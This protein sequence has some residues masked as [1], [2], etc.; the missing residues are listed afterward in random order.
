VFDEIRN[1]FAMLPESRARGYTQGRF[2]YNVRGGRCEACEGNGDQR[3]E[4]HFLPDVSVTCHVCDGKRYNRET[5]EVTYKGKNI[6]DV[7]DMDA[8][9]AL[10]FFSGIPKIRKMLQIIN[11]IGLGYLRLGQ[12]GPSLSAGEAQR[13]KLS[14]ELKTSLKNKTLYL[15]D[16]P[17]VGLHFY[18]I[19][20]LL[21]IINRLV[22]RGN[23]V[24]IIEHNLEVVAAADWIIDLGPEGGEEGG[25]IVAQ[26]SPEDVAKN[27]KSYTGKFLKEKLNK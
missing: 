13:I 14:S 11:D 1:L 20:K 16:E 18:D 17:T 7:L 21:S 3:I 23:T 15:L 8:E 10:E 27:K 4:M 6:S 22:D 26:G 5:L 24:I 9:E 12:P 2:S 25:R 19:N